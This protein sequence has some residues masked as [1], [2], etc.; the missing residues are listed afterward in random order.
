MSTVQISE[1]PMRKMGVE[2]VVV[3][4]GVGKS[5]EPLQKA[6]TILEELFSQKPSV[7]KAKR[8]I[9]DF[10][11][12][13]GEPIG[14]TVTLRGEKAIE[15]LKKLL[16]A[17]GN[18]LPASS[19]DENGSVSFGLREHIDIPGVKYKPELGIFGMN[20]SVFITRPGYRVRYRRRAPA[21][22]GRS[23]RVSREDSMEFLKSNFGVE[24]VQVEGATR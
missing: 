13:R 2:K 17:K 5:G 9:R 21:K 10:G 24:V 19:F 7:R 12:R 14:V 22:V 18:R 15:A 8:T 16:Q 23:H 11:V 3:N 1:N 6:S 4:I 20:V